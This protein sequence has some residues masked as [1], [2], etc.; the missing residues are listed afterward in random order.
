MH[1]IE[2]DRKLIEKYNISGPRYTSYP[3]VLTFSDAFAASDYQEVASES[4][5]AEKR[6]DLSLY[7]HIPF[8]ARLC[9]YC[10]CNKVVTKKRDMAIPYLERLKTELKR[11]AELYGSDRDVAQ[12][13]WGGGTPTFLSDDQIHALMAQTRHSFNLKS[14]QSGEFS[15]EIDPRE[16]RPDTLATLRE[17]GFNRMSLG[18][19]DFEPAV[20]KAVN[21]IQ[22]EELT[23]SVIHSA[24]ALGFRSISVDLI[25]GLPF[26]NLDTVSRTLE[27]VQ[28]LNPDRISLY[29]YAHLPDRFMPQ[30][31]LRAEDMPQA[32][33]KLDMLKLYIET[34]TAA[35]YAYI[36]MDHFAK[37]T[38][39]LY[40][41]QENGSLY[42]NFQGYST[43]AE[44]DLIAMGVSA[45]GTVGGN[46]YQNYKDLDPYYE[47]LDSG[48]LPIEK[49]YRPSTEDRLRRALIMRLICDFKLDFQS[50]AERWQIDFP[51]HFRNELE[52]LRDMAEDGLLNLNPEGIL[53]SARG[54][55]LI[56][57]ICMVFDQ[58]IPPPVIVS[59]NEKRPRFS[60]VI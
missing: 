6:K 57:N 8:C 45:I 10:A 13:H 38:D 50:F 16:V 52:R 49:G 35:G 2:F 28:Q 55:L 43:H 7:F 14:D 56:R 48:E 44:C 23:E 19:Q 25:Y 20:Q 3:T 39:A 17:S 30:K 12:L 26:Q 11:H 24:R 27:K 59:D 1:Q 51:T 46:F 60:K 4:N 47:A 36:G 34:L 32:A 40:L 9:Y 21:R 29:N 54:R 58:Y 41:A 37:K 18:I 22:S 5:T 53:V 33:E 42:R 15:I 31:R